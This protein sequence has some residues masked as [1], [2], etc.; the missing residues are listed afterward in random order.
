MPKQHTHVRGRGF[1]Q[2]H[3]PVLCRDVHHR[4]GG[5]ARVRGRA[6]RVRPRGLR[7]PARGD[8]FRGRAR[9]RRLPA[10]DCVGRGGARGLACGA[11]ARARHLLQSIR[12]GGH[13]RVVRCQLEAR[14]A[15]RVCR[16][17]RVHAQAVPH[18]RT[19]AHV[20]GDAPGGCSGACV[21]L[22]RS[23]RL[24]GGA[25]SYRVRRRL[26]VRP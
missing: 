11:R 24:H 23:G 1:P 19:C 8:I 18:H 25:P 15:L 12:S 26:G 22:P 17:H 10:L 2:A 3:D 20:R 9:N 16:G 7:W 6:R 4:V 14:H 21:R 13:P 5:D